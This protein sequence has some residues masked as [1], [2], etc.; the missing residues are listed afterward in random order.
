MPK[1][2]GSNVRLAIIGLGDMG[3]GHARGFDAVEGCEIVAVVDA[4]PD[5]QRAHRVDYARNAPR[6]YATTRDMLAAEKPDACVVA[7]PDL[8]HRAVAEEVV[9]AGCD[10]FLEKPVATTLADAD[11][12]NKAVERA[13]VL[14]QIGLVY[15]YSNLYR[16]MAALGR[17]PGHDVTLMWCKELR[18]CFPQRPWFYSQKETGGTIV[19]KDCHHFDI[20]N[21]VINSEPT[22]VHAFGGQH[23]WKPGA[24]IECSYCPDPPRRIDDIDTVDHAVIS[25]EYANGA[26]ASLT[27]CMYLRPHNVMP[28]GLEIGAIAR[29]GRQMCAYNDQR[30]GVGGVGEPFR[31]ENLDMLAD[32][33]GIGHIGCQEQRR[34]FLRCVRERRRPLADFGVGRNSLRVA[35]AAEASIR[36][37]RVIDLKEL[38]Q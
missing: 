4:L 28:E 34:D 27:L 38:E 7:V 12:I 1:P 24:T 13:G 26:R 3:C 10:L 20:F 35:L 25:V 14:M 15:R 2:S 16:R 30:L 29:S 31:F 9:A 22:K 32:N 8:Q 6:W 37:Q 21:W 19:E 5:A 33:N 18:Q 23:V 17:E 11:A 36:Q